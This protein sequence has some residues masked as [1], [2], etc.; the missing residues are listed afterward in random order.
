MAQ[1]LRLGSQ[2]KIRPKT[3]D[4][5]PRHQPLVSIY[6]YVRMCRY[7]NIYT[8]KIFSICTE[9]RVSVVTSRAMI[10]SP[11]RPLGQFPHRSIVP[12]DGSAHRDCST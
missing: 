11:S 1:L 7:I 5:D 6:S 2:P 10:T 4:K 12:Y 8:H 3:T 9:T